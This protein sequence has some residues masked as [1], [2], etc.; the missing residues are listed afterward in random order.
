[1]L[2]EFG[3]S[4]APCLRTSGWAAAPLSG[5]FPQPGAR[6][7]TAVRS[8]PLKP[9]EPGFPTPRGA[10]GFRV[11]GLGAESL[12]L[13]P[14]RTWPELVVERTAVD[15]GDLAS[16]DRQ[17]AGVRFTSDGA[18]ILLG[19]GRC[20]VSREPLRAE[21]ALRHD[22]TDDELVHPYLAGVAAVAGRWNGLETF[23]AGAFVGPDGAWALLGERESGKS[24]TLA[25]LAARGSAIVSD[26]LLALRGTTA[27]AGPRSIDLRR[28]A[29][30]R[31]PDADAL[32][33]VGARERWR[34]R[35]PPIAPECPF[36]GW[37]FLEWGAT[38][39]LR[40]L[41]A[42]ELLVRL[43]AALTLPAAPTSP[44]AL[45][46]LASLPAFVLGRPR[47]FDA[48]DAVADFLFR[49]LA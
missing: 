27:L 8:E 33:V 18:E 21:F 3:R 10:Y 31:V 45:L 26:D 6:P 29:A 19:G 1:M 17:N 12:L 20:R 28:E 34:V 49:G 43:S 30:E 44:S 11:R 37:V 5:G 47:D 2:N 32:G 39:E 36:H 14:P 38:N 22:A 9:S 23:H 40:R 41:G 48:I 13:E 16:T 15:D 46:L 42:S 24:T 25:T 7:R 4:H 35:L